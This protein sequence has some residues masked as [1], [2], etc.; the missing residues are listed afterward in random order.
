MNRTDDISNLFS[1]FGAS[2]DSYHEFESQFDYKEKQETPALEKTAATSDDMPEPQGVAAPEVV[3]EPAPVPMIK[4]VEE[5]V[6]IAPVEPQTTV[7]PIPLALSARTQVVEPLLVPEIELTLQAQELPLASQ[8]HAISALLP[9][10]HEVTTST[11][12]HVADAE[13]IAELPEAIEFLESPAAPEQSPQHIGATAPAKLRNLLAE[14]I[15][16]RQVQ[17]HVLSEDA[18]RQA[19]AKARP[20]KCKAHIVVLVSLKG[21]VGKTTLSAGLASSL[22]MGGGRTLAIDLDP[23]NALQFHLGVEHSVS[24]I[25]SANMAGR[26]WNDRLQHG[27]DGSLLLPYGV[28]SDDERR[29]LISEMTEDRHWLARQLDRMNLGEQDVVIIDTPT[30]STQYLEQALDVAD[31]VIVVTTADAASFITLDQIDRVLGATD[32]RPA[33]SHC[34][35]VVNQ[36]DASREFSRDMLQV[37]KRRLGEQLMAV[38]SLDNTLGEAL[39][40]GRNPLATAEASVAREDVLLLGEQLKA[41]FEAPSAQGIEAQ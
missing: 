24:G 6:E 40:Y 38:V 41:R 22:R 33:Y 12:L 8:A 11:R 32:V 31:E 34:N 9:A 4:A 30:G 17:A 18:L 26:N 16:A 14:V 21:G 37:L 36:F 1:R 28:L 27:F 23:Q 19:A 20:A 39:A 29:S 35:Y 5:I 2:S 25:G 7:E 3:A 10:L 15:Q 13:P